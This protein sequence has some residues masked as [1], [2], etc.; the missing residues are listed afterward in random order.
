MFHKQKKLHP[1]MLGMFCLGVLASCQAGISSSTD[2]STVASST[3]ATTNASGQITETDDGTSTNST[4]G[5]T[6]ETDSGSTQSKQVDDFI[7]GKSLIV[8]IPTEW[9]FSAEEGRVSAASYPPPHVG[10]AESLPEG[11]NISFLPYLPSLNPETE[12][13]T[14]LGDDWKQNGHPSSEGNIRFYLNKNWG[15]AVAGERTNNSLNSQDL[16]LIEN[17]VMSV[18]I[19]EQP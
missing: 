9:F 11:L 2:T 3:K 5:P 12:I 4:E 8:Q 19:G 6:T 13:A 7:E 1:F 17:V 15:I 14:V 16:Q 18:E 10:K